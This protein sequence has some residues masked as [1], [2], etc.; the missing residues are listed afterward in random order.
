MRVLK[1]AIL[2]LLD[3]CE[4]TGYDITKHF[5]DS[6]GQFWSAKHSQIYPELKRLTEE[7]FIEFDVRIQGKKAGEEGLSN[8]RGGSSSIA[9]VVK[10]KRPD[11]RNNKG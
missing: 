9:S 11:P 6:L 2:G 7:G 4:L 3:Q 5:K 10:D 8:H 1:Y